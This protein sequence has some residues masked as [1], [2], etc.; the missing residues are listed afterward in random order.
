[1]GL[2]ALL[3]GRAAG[4]RARGSVR[5][6]QCWHASMHACSISGWDLVVEPVEVFQSQS[7]LS[8]NEVLEIQLGGSTSLEVWATTV[9]A[10]TM[11]ESGGEWVSVCVCRSGITVLCACETLV[12]PVRTASGT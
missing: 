2:R 9:W 10:L 5:A 4:R 7:I 12:L 8:A 1:V 3:D 6:C 11:G